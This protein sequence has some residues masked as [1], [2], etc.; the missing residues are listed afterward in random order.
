M[1]KNETESDDLEGDTIRVSLLF[2][3]P[4]LEGVERAAGRFGVTRS[5]FIRQAC[6]QALAGVQEEPDWED[7]LKSTRTPFYYDLPAL[8]RRLQHVGYLTPRGLRVLKQRIVDTVGAAEVLQALPSPY[9]QLLRRLGLT[10]K[11]VDE[12]LE[13]DESIALKAVGG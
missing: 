5:A 8:A 9:E 4:L 1:A 7:L 11:K 10:K 12:A 13:K 6:Q 3:K 2:E